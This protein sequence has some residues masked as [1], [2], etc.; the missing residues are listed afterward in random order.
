[1]KFQNYYQFVINFEIVDKYNFPD[2]KIY[3]TQ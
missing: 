2:V 3:K 1:M